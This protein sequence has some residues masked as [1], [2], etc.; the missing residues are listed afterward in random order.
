MTAKPNMPTPP[1]TGNSTCTSDAGGVDGSTGGGATRTGSTGTAGGYSRGGRWNAWTA[2]ALIVGRVPHTDSP[3]TRAGVMASRAGNPSLSR[4]TRRNAVPNI[5][6]T[7]EQLQSVASQLN[8]GAANIESI[9]SQLAAQV[10]PL[11]GEWQGIAP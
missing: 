6:V 1:T 7:P 9:L 11:Q 4:P 10:A 5:A 8:A 3:D 2:S